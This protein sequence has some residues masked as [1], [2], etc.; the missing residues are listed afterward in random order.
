MVKD[1]INSRAKGPRTV[2][3]RQTVQGRANEGGLRIGEMERDVIIA[4]GMA[5]FLYDSLITRG[6]NYYMAICNQTGTIAI[7]NESKNLFLSPQADG[8]IQF[9]GLLDNNISV[10]DISRFGRSFS[11]VNVPYAF[12]LLMQELGTMN[13]S[14]R[15]ITDDNINQIESLSFSKTLTLSLD[16]S[17][18][19]LSTPAENKIKTFLPQSNTTP[20]PEI[21]KT[22]KLSTTKKETIKKPTLTIGD[23]VK[24]DEIVDLEE[25]KKPLMQPIKEAIESLDKT[26]DKGIEA[27]ATTLN[28]KKEEEITEELDLDEKEKEEL[29][30]IMREKKAESEAKKITKSEIPATLQ[31][32]ELDDL[33][34]EE[35]EKKTIA[36][37]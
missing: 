15:I 35:S 36:I 3:T 31:P 22:K 33:Q 8:P 21:P 5:E 29:E 7:Y 24:T 34:P 13:I 11:I 18:K 12:K 28:P 27:L 2:L 10:I 14:L 37:N 19:D 6:D 30:K 4:H 26:L 1:K 23:T 32:I 25:E 17:T 20:V 16:N 9:A